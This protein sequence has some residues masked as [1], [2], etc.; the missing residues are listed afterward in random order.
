MDD[1]APDVKAFLDYI[2]GVSSH[3]AFVQDIEHAIQEL[4]MQEA[5]RVS[6]MTFEMKMKEMRKEGREEGR[7]EGRMETLLKNIRTLMANLHMTAEE[8]MNTLAVST[9]EREKIAPMI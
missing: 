8:A 1:V 6:Y 7:A 9:A 4:K 3:D 2:D 5:E